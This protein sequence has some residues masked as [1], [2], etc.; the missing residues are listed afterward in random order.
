MTQIDL[1]ISHFYLKPTYIRSHLSHYSLILQHIFL[2]SGFTFHLA[3]IASFQGMSS[4]FFHDPSTLTL[5]LVFDS[6]PEVLLHAVYTHQC[7]LSNLHSTLIPG[8]I[9]YQ[10]PAHHDS[11]LLHE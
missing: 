4:I 11:F 3:Y 8:I 9:L 10:Y 5:I 7:K 2:Q 1:H 6:L